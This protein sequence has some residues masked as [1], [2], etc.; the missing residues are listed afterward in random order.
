[1]IKELKNITEEDLAYMNSHKVTV[2]EKIDLIYFKVIV[3]DKDVCVVTSK[4]KTIT[5]VDCIIN[6]VYKN[7]MQFVDI[8]IKWNYDEIF[9]TFGCCEIGFFYKPVIKTCMISYPYI[10]HDFIIGNL[11][12]KLKLNNDVEKLSSILGCVGVLS[13]ICVK[14]SLCKFDN[15]NDYK[16]IVSKMTDN[17]TWSGN[18]IDDIEGIILS[19]GK[20]N[21]KI[22][23]NNTEPNIEKTT[24][25]LYRDTILENFCNVI[26]DSNSVKEILESRKSY[27]DKV[28]DLFLEYINKTN[29][30][31]KMYIEPDDILPPTTGYIGDVDYDALP[32]TVRL[33]C[34][35]NELYKNI[36]RILLVTF[37]RSVFDN[38]FKSFNQDTR[39]KLTEI[40]AK[41]NS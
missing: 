38:K 31:T 25:K 36:L 30:F 10:D 39:A 33:I 17:K 22:T 6:S 4:H 15:I 16:N 41:L 2:T 21:Y 18:S 37:N 11:Y 3:S 23:I 27:I 13:P 7:I 12:T 20:C 26:F 40:L 24:K 1:M 29:I 5:D 19:C 28:S 9:S 34:K 35:G 8:N 14:E 32:S